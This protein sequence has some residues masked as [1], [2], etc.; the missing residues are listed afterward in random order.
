MFRKKRIEMGMMKYS[1][2]VEMY[3]DSI[4]DREFIGYLTSSERTFYVFFRHVI[5]IS[6]DNKY[7]GKIGNIASILRCVPI[8]ARRNVKRLESKGMITVR[9]TGRENIYELSNDWM[10][11]KKEDG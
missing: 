8:T 9:R 6:K 10:I 1:K 11:Y 4:R 3:L 7:I 2:I 5:K